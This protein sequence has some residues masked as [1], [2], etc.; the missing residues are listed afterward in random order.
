MPPPLI[1]L[2]LHGNDRILA[3]MASSKTIAVNR[4]AFHDYHILDRL[5]AGI[6]LTGSEIKSVRAG[7]VNLRD[8]YAKV[9]NNELWL[10]NAHIARYK[11]ASRDVPEPA[12]RRKLLLHRKQIDNLI[13]MTVRK[14]LTIVP[15]KLYIKNGVAKV[16]LGIVRGKKLYDKREAI[17][18]RELD[19]ETDRM[20]KAAGRRR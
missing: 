20:L 2:T 16:E 10:F 5:E 18:S 3:Q 4:R 12:R 17:R 1:L 9:E 7:T 13:G 14:G 19:R 6:V 8:A 11:A 15:L